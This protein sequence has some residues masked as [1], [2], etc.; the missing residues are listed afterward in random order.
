M[1]AETLSSFNLALTLRTAAPRIEAHYQ[2][3]HN[4]VEP[5]LSEDDVSCPVWVL[6]G[7]KK[8][9][10]PTLN[11][12]H[13]VLKG[14]LKY[15]PLQFDRVIGNLSAP[16]SVLYGDLTSPTFGHFHKILS[17]TALSGK[18]SYIVRHR[19]P[20]AGEQKALGVAGY[21]V[22]LALKRTDYIVIDDRDE[23][24]G[25]EDPAATSAKGVVLEDA[26]VADL[27]PLSKAEL[28]GLGIKAASF[29]MESELPFRMLAR[30]SQDF[31]RYSNA[32][33]A[34][35]ASSQF[36]KEHQSNSGKLVPSG[37]NI[38]WLNGMRVEHRE[39]DAF[40]L[41]DKIRKERAFIRGFGALGLAA[42]QAIDLLS[43]NN[44]KT[45]ATDDDAPRFDWRDDKEDGK[46]ILWLNDIEKDKR[47]AG[48]QTHLA[49]LLQRTYPGQLP[50]VRK[51]I[52][53]LV[54]PV[55]LSLS[56]D[57]ELVIEQ[58]SSFV[59][60]KLPLRFGLVL[61]TPT[62]AATRQAKI[63]YYLQE[64]YGISA[65]IAYLEAYHASHGKLSAHA[66]NFETAI[67]SS[68]V[69]EYRNPLTLDE[70]MTSSQVNEHIERAKEWTKR[71]KADTE[72][73]PIFVNG[74]V[75]PRDAYWMQAMSQLVNG[76]VQAIQRAVYQHQVAD[77]E[78]APM[79]FIKNALPSRNPLVI[80]ENNSKLKL[81]SLNAL[82]EE[83][84]DALEGLPT[85]PASASAHAQ[86]WAEL[87]VIVDTTSDH[88]KALLESVAAF[89]ES[90]PEIEIILVPTSPTVES[91]ANIHEE[92]VVKPFHALFEGLS[93]LKQFIKE[94]TGARTEGTDDIED[95]VY[96]E[97]KFNAINTMLT[98]FGMEPGQQGLLLNGRLVGPIPSDT[99]F[100]ADDIAQLVTYERAKRINPVLEALQELD[101]LS[102]LDCPSTSAKITS[103]VTSSF[104]T[105]VPGGI[106]EETSSVRMDAFKFLGSEH[107]AIE[108]GEAST[109]SIRIVATIDP[110]SLH[111]QRLIP[112]LKVLSELEGVY[113]KLFLNPQER[114]TEI[115]IKRFYRYVLDSKP[116]F[117][118]GGDLI[119]A[120]ARFTNVP[121]EALLNLG[122]DVPPS[123]LVAPK[124]SV[125]DLDNIKL[126]SVKGD[127]LTAT[128]ELEH[129]LI[130]GHSHDVTNKQPP[131]GAQL[132]LGTARNPHAADT[133]IMANLGYF[134][135]KANPGYYNIGLQEGR[136]ADIFNMDNLG[137]PDTSVDA[138]ASNSVALMS[139]QGVTLYPRL[140]RKPGQAIEDVLEPK[141]P[142]KLDFFEKGKKLAQ[143][144]LGLA[145][146]STASVQN[147]DINIFSVASGHLYERMLNIMMVSVMKHTK[148]TVKFWFI[149]QFLS[150]SFK[151]D[152]P[153]LAAE[154]GFQYEMVTYKWPHWLRGQT[155]KQREI[156]GYKILFLDVLF[157]LSLDKV[158]FVDADQI[159]RTDMMDL[160]NTGTHTPP[161][162]DARHHRRPIF[163]T[164]PNRAST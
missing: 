11:E 155:E 39:L 160:V 60:R 109:A 71:L 85:L 158:I 131:R 16:S 118:A 154:Y 90:H 139:F 2:Y 29:I 149:E 59:K 70:V 72:V 105:N 51:D 14:N 54:I 140:S 89:R 12:P 27:K 103:L 31:P 115:P 148:H 32:I 74:A 121:Q 159:V 113:M 144:V 134:Q 81:F 45:I 104:V 120:G 73:P 93:D 53:N 58:L 50:Q 153:A 34:H 38:F 33:A 126:S 96:V 124:E 49:H 35:N 66:A 106:Y 133:L 125:H 19:R 164:A 20:L 69:H 88:G 157:P 3:Y 99:T 80:P 110:A 83:H 92:M 41:L 28:A 163:T 79:F 21:G 77:D 9:C 86:D 82:Y 111:S 43:N 78:W 98:K 137:I 145:K 8:Y 128:Y 116:R 5:I 114:L 123:W 112:I 10:S 95:H 87:L 44:I 94:N 130:E 7:G 68:K 117:S 135:F 162:A 142:S 56:S 46:A 97:K 76:D 24:T 23:D 141:V 100:D 6:F 136:S 147:A 101:L 161:A 57:V 108:V 75:V 62:E 30:L 107:S 22:E 150:P 156:W 40:T 119:S 55:D 129:I 67:N 37:L 25:K 127:M 61:L 26:E 36:I 17:Q 47:Y 48:W 52:F 143:N 18:T 42:P 138:T 4:Y 151:E 132:V 13:G 102:L 64:N 63:V 122:M 15:E 1:D 65:A 84:I 146:P 152:I 91:I